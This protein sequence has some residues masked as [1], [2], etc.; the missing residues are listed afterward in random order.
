MK[1]QLES[2]KTSATE[3][4]HLIEVLALWNKVTEQGIEPEDVARFKLDKQFMTRRQCHEYQQ[5]KYA[6][7]VVTNER[8]Q[9]RAVPS[10]ANAVVMKDGST[11]ELN[12]WVELP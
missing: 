4:S 12:P 11:I 10:H 5:L 1:N 9:R 8:G 2:L 7:E 6:K 3:R